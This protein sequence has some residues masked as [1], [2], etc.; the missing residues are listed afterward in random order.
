MHRRHALTLIKAFG[1]ISVSAA[2]GT[3]LTSSAE[4]SGKKREDKKKGGGESYIQLPMIAVFVPTG[5]QKNGTLTVELG[6]DVP[7]AK[8]REKVS[9]YIPRL[10]DAF[11]SRLQTYAM[12]LNASKAIDA[13]Y[14]VHELQSQTDGLL[15]TSGAK[16]L[17]GSIMVN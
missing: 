2:T 17:L 3:A 13:D 4:A 14:I 10:R 15:R 1:L 11:V 12:T 8:L 5:R 9:A 7:D 6:L 16:V